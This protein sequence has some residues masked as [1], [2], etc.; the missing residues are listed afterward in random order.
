MARPCV[1]SLVTSGVEDVTFSLTL[2]VTLLPGNSGFSV[3]KPVSHPAQSLSINSSQLQNTIVD[4]CAN[5]FRE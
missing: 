3:V 1:T 4:S 5:T 2:L